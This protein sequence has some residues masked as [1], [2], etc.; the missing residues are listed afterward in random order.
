MASTFFCLIIFFSSIHLIFANFNARA[1]QSAGEY[2]TN[3]DFPE[4]SYLQNRPNTAIGFTG[5]GSRAYVAAIGQLAGLNQLGLLKNV[6]Y[7]GGISGG[8]WATTTFSY[9]QHT[10]DDAVLLGPIVQPEKISPSVLK[11]MDPNCARAFA[12]ANLTLIGLS[13]YLDGTVKTAA[14]AWALGVSKTYLEPAGIQ[15]GKFF[16]WNDNTVQ[17]I[18]KRNPQLTADQFTL[19]TKADRPYPII[20]TALIGPAAGAPYQADAQNYSMIELTPMY[21]GQL[22]TQEI[23]F[24]YSPLNVKHTRTVGG[25]VEPFAWPHAGLPPTTGLSKRQ[26]AGILSVP[27]PTEAMD[28]RYS[29]AASSYAPGSF[30]ESLRPADVANALGMHFDYW[31]PSSPMPIGE[32]TLFADGG[33]YEN[34]PLIS[35]LQRRVNKIVLFIN[36]VTPLQPSEKYNP[37]TDDFTGKELSDSLTAFFGVLG[38]NASDFNDRSYEYEKDQV[39][40]REDYGRVVSALQVAQKDGHGMVVTVNL[41]TIENAWWGIPAGLNITLTVSYLGRLQAWE[42]QL[43]NEMKTL[44]VPQENADDLSVD[45]DHGPYRNFPHY[46]TLGGEINAE[47]ANALADLTG[48][49]VLQHADDFRSIL[50]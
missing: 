16:S 10:Q 41:V 50:S 2:P 11:E 42:S 18:I 27:E 26:T 44:L 14:D 29:A 6:R 31:S 8:A 4:S 9:A 3:K 47:R 25:A 19:L 5:G 36:G 12:A 20:G 17:D 22:R 7:V 35:F 39:F 23:E 13:A 38:V 34:I 21:I 37:Y 32:D 28:L 40:A 49:A 30:V 46:F 45:V 24:H 43:S 48:W 15:P 1:W 33:C